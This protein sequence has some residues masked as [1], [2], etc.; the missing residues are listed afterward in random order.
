MER[1]RFVIGLLFW[2]RTIILKKLKVIG[3]EMV[4]SIEWLYWLFDKRK[5]IQRGLPKNAQYFKCIR[6]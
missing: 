1:D 6:K 4:L 3:K 2:K 5:L